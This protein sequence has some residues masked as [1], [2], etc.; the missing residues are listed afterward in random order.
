MNDSQIVSELNSKFSS[1]DIYV[2]FNENKPLVLLCDGLNK[3]LA[4]S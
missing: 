2:H 4:L 3:V 1:D